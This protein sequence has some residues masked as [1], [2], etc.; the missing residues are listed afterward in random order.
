MESSR[1]RLTP[2]EPA[3]V[4]CPGDSE[5]REIGFTAQLELPDGSK[6][7]L[8]IWNSDCSEPFL[9]FEGA[10]KTLEE[11]ERPSL[12]LAKRRR[13]ASKLERT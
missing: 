4:S 2:L 12:L 7:D 11:A 3:C 5:A 8:T 10:A 13:A 1:A 6:K 9:A